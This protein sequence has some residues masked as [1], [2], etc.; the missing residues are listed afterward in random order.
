M[1]LVLVVPFCFVLNAR[2][3]IYQVWSH[4]NQYLKFN[5]H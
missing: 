5:C 2:L 1:V 4:N 3:G